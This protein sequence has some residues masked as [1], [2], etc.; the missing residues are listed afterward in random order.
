MKKE[1]QSYSF[2]ICFLLILIAFGSFFSVRGFRNVV[3][4]DPVPI[5]PD[6]KFDNALIQ[7]IGEHEQSVTQQQAK[8]NPYISERLIVKSNDPTL[9]PEDYGA[10]DAI[11][12]RSGTYVLQF[13]STLDARKA[14]ASLKREDSTVYVEPDTYL[15]ASGFDTQID[16]SLWGQ[17][18]KMIGADKYAESLAGTTRS[19]TVAVLDTGISY[20]S[21]KL[22][23]RL[24]TSL[25]QSSFVEGYE[26]ANQ[27]SY[28]TGNYLKHG[29]HVAGIIAQCVEQLPNISILPIR[30]LNN[31]GNGNVTQVSKAIRYAADKKADVINLSLCGYTGEISETIQSAIQYAVGKGTV[32]VAVA[33]ND[34][35]DISGYTPSNIKECIVVGAVDSSFDR[36]VRCNYGSTLDVMAPGVDVYSTIWNG[37]ENGYGTSTGT[38]MACPHVAAAAAMLKLAN[39]GL[40]PTEI[41]TMLCEK[42]VRDLGASGKDNYYGYGMIYLTTEI[43]QAAADAVITQISQLP[44]TVTLSSKTAIEAAAAAYEALTEDQKKL[45][46]NYSALQSA[47]T[48]LQKAVSEAGNGNEQNSGT[49]NSGNGN[50]S[51]TQ[52]SSGKQNSSSGTAAYAAS[53]PKANVTYRVPLRRKQKTRYLKVVG[54]AGGDKVVSWKSSDTRKVKVYGKSDGTCLIK[55]GT[56]TGYAK[57]TATC[58]SGRKV[59]F[60][61][62]IQKNKVRTKKLQIAKKTVQVSAGRK[63]KLHISRY[64][65]TAVDKLVYRSN[66]KK[67]AKVSKDGVISAVSPGTT[68][69]IVTSG[70]AKLKVKVVVG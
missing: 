32:V 16:E 43:D 7:M 39:S 69:I 60:Y 44:Q 11:R 19:V 29:T 40:S 21:P 61:F 64:P 17:T 52:N 4:A 27:D 12:D 49:G 67:I 55:A 18:A 42:Y 30:V 59:Y 34:N 70:K 25:E 6:R 50:T 51:G 5:L 31:D 9:D 1:K 3:Y 68:T 2:T 35:A 23:G 28:T 63:L 45:V 57:I 36:Y 37:A 20:S 41:E 13:D 65:V 26:N 15:F 66:N 58:Q 47:Q 62:R 46:T 10:V 48:A 8:R 14:E 38:S 22:A 56:R 53:K 24:D 54:L 33:G